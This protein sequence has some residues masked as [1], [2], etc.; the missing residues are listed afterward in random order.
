MRVFV[1]G[2]NGFLGRNLRA[3]FSEVEDTKFIWGTTSDSKESKKFRNNYEDVKDQLESIDIDCILH[4]AAIIPASF[5][6]ASFTNTFLPNAMMIDNLYQLAIKKKVKKFIY[7]ST[8]GSMRNIR[9]YKISDYYTL[10]KIH[11]EHICSLMEKESIKT[12]SLRLPSP[13]GPFSN[14]RNVINSFIRNAVEGRDINVYGSGMREQN[15]LYIKDLAKAIKLFINS[16]QDIEG[17]YEIVSKENTSMLYLANL[18]KQL[19][20]SKSEIIVGKNVDPQENY[21]PVY[22]YSRAYNAVG[23][24]PSYTIEEGL[25]EYINWYRGNLC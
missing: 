5:Y 18:V 12:A 20:I 15:F 9:D 24:E 10:S 6:E 22:D 11:G 1:T 16:S 7:I 14:P 25:K 23:Y 2:S 4:L 3:L 17:I 13:Y 21:R 19:S 8:F